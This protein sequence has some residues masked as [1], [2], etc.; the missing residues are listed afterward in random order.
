M[1]R[2]F[3]LSLW[4]SVMGA[5]EKAAAGMCWKETHRENR[6]KAI[7]HPYLSPVLLSNALYK[8]DSTSSALTPQPTRGELKGW[9][10]APWADHRPCRDWPGLAPALWEHRAQSLAVA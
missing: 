4:G 1:C 7:S 5:E 9:G 2:K 6:L 10:K 3:Y 8:A